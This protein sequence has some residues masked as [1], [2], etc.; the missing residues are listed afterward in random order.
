MRASEHI[1]VLLLGVVLFGIC[2]SHRANA[3]PPV[4]HARQM[5]PI[6][7]A[8]I[9]ND[10]NNVLQFN[11]IV[12]CEQAILENVILDFSG[13]DELNDVAQTTLYTGGPNGQLLTTTDLGSTHSTSRI[14]RFRL[15]HELKQGDNWFWVS[16]QVNPKASLLHEIGVQCVSI[17]TSEGGIK[18]Q[19]ASSPNRIGYAL[20]QHQEGGTHTYRIPAVA[21]AKDGSLLAVFDM[22]HTKSR[23]LQEDIDIGLCKS[24]DGGQ[25]WSPP[26]PI[27]D[28]GKWGGR[29]ESHNGISDPGIIVDPVTGKIFCFA[30][31]MHGKP[32]KHQ[33]TA[34]GSEPGYEIGKAAQFLMASSVDH[35]E[36]WSDL[37]NMTRAL[38]QKE[39]VLFAPSPQNGISLRDGTLLA[40]VQGRN[41]DG[42]PF[43]TI[44][45]SQDHGKSWKVAKPAF[46]G[47]SE[48]QAV[49]LRDGRI[50]LNMRSKR[51]SGKNRRSVFVTSDRGMTWK[52]HSTHQKALIEP[53]CNGSTI[54]VD[55]EEHGERKSV[56]LFANPQSTKSRVNHT[57]QV[58]FNEGLTWPK[59]HHHLLDTG[60]GFGY[61]SLVQIDPKH[62][63]IVFEGSRSHIMFMKF[64]IAE[65]TD[66]SQKP[67]SGQ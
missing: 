53:Y 54:R 1:S 33:W 13:T 64:T 21:R 61:P 6:Y 38:K 50:M 31:W 7:P 47:S 25:T 60:L 14:V 40:P 11:V 10:T 43:S 26:R 37:H 36:T 45:T 62:V 19:A 15:D 35:G 30:V 56:L 4:V 24:T 41:K 67:G 55:Y 9:R 16:C 46:V 17:G 51:T 65:L 44:M 23:D 22:R 48:C 32:G 12:M 20:C 49:E 2:V 59:S 5:H 34:D 57:I 66:G 52:P 39:W 63:G 8:L 27:M 3:L 28:R 29:S 58:S 42:N 18:P